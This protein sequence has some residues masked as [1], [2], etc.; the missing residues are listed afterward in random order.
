DSGQRQWA[1]Y[2]GGAAQESS[3][4]ITGGMAGDIYLCGTTRSVSG[5]ATP[6]SHQPAA[7]GSDDAFL[8]R[9]D[10]T[11]QRRWGTYLGGSSG[12]AGYQAACGPWGGVYMAGYA[13]STSGIATAVSH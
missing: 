1:T 2:Y 5:I 12:D 3:A 13:Q 11:G 6:G 4:T 9:F 7:G 8:V 10:V